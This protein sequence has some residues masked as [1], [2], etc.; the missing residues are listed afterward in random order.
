VIALVLIGVGVYF[1]GGFELASVIL[2]ILCLVLMAGWF[3]F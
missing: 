1:F 3:I 2:F